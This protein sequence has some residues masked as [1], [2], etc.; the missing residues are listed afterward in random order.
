MPV[1]QMSCPK[2]G[3][4]AA[5]YAEDKWQCLSCQ[6]KFIYKN[7][8]ATVNNTTNVNVASSLLL[9]VEPAD[10]ND[11]V[12]IERPYLERYP[13]EQM[14]EMQ[15]AAKLRSGRTAY[16][17]KT[18]LLIVLLW[19][20]LTSSHWLLATSVVALIFCL[21]L[22]IDWGNVRYAARMA[23]KAKQLETKTTTVGWITLCP[24]CKNEY[25][26]FTMAGG[27]SETSSV[28]CT[29]CGKQFMLIKGEAFK[30]KRTPSPST[31]PTPMPMPIINA[32]LASA[33]IA[34]PTCGIGIPVAT[35]QRGNNVCPSC[36]KEYVAE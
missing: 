9:D 31:E 26:R 30:I 33:F 32:G 34:C 3:K 4:Q 27:T 20:L 28:H 7:E 18:I 12:M 11:R 24:Y 19:A 21:A 13:L 23:V 10:P 8:S 36:K 5:E 35:I 25:A 14:P 22:F 29:K 17:V 16:W 15:R 6:H 1:Y 2:C